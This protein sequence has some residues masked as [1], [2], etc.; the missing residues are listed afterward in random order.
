[1]PTEV[2]GGSFWQAMIDWV[3]ADGEGTEDLFQ[4]VEDSWPAG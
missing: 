4:T 2:G 3:A 1:M